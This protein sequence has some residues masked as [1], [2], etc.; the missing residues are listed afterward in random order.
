MRGINKYQTDT[1]QR[2]DIGSDGLVGGANED[3]RAN[4]PGVWH[5]NHFGGTFSG[6]SKGPGGD[7]PH[8][9]VPPS[10]AINYLIK[11]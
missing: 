7:Q 6:K 2:Y 8:D 10:I 4:Q 5:D 3:G 11:T 1:L 9:N